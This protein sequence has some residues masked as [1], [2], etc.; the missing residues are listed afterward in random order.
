[1]GQGRA[2]DWQKMD[3]VVRTVPSPVHPIRNYPEFN[4]LF[5][6]SVDFG[7]K[8]AESSM[9][10]MHT[11]E[12]RGRVQLKLDLD[13]KELS[14]QFPLKVNGNARNFRFELPIARL[15]HVY[16][17]VGNLP[18]QASLII[19]FDLSPR[20]FMQMIEGEEMT[21]GNRHTSFSVRDRL[22]VDWNTWF[23]ETD[24]L[25]IKLKKSLQDTA[26]MNHKDDAIIDIGMSAYIVHGATN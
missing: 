17:R 26:L 14:V 18:G 8:D 22:W 23:R 3:P 19:P 7:I 10:S 5:A 15:S 9:I 1:M 11:I 16:K 6:N 4:I 20:F 12:A 24:V 13:R 2:Y 21:N 25:D